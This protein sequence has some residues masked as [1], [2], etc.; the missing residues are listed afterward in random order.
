MGMYLLTGNYFS[1]FLNSQVCDNFKCYAQGEIFFWVIMFIFFIIFLI[2]LIISLTKRQIDKDE[3]ELMKNYAD[4]DH[5][6]I[7]LD[8]IDKD[9]T[10]IRK[11]R[12]YR[13]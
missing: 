1:G 5:V 7:N 9:K 8:K 4:K 12:E 10:G 6:K 13:R 11:C 3:K 2:L